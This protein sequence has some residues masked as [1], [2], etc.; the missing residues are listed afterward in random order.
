MKKN[1]KMKNVRL[2]KMKEEIKK[3]TEIK[4]LENIEKE[5]KIIKVEIEKLNDPVLKKN[6]LKKLECIQT[7]EEIFLLHKEILSANNEV[8]KRNEELKEKKEELEDLDKKREKAS[9]DIELLEIKKAEFVK[10]LQSLLNESEEIRKS[11]EREIQVIETT[12]IVKKRQSILL[13]TLMLVYVLQ[14]NMDKLLKIPLSLT[15]A[16]EIT[17]KLQEK[18]EIIIHYEYHYEDMDDVIDMAMDSID[19]IEKEMKDSLESIKDLSKE[20]EKE[21]AEYKDLKEFQSI[22]DMFN[23][24]EKAIE[25]ECEA[26]QDI[27]K[28]LDKSSDINKEKVLKIDLNN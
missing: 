26:V 24:I 11:V 27:E 3:V 14:S 8:K 16:N 7:N 18:E 23:E 21:F 6:F 20:Y 4:E 25:K 19:D 28:N 5:L 15:I 10:G 9:D 13:D 1:L 22:L 17:D 12:E 2:Q